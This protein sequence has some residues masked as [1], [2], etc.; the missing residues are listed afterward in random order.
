MRRTGFITALV[1]GLPAALVGGFFVGQ[2]NSPGETAAAQVTVTATVTETT[3][4][5]VTGTAEGT[6]PA[7]SVD[8][9][10]QTPPRPTS[11]ATSAATPEDAYAILVDVNTRWSETKVGPYAWN[12]EDGWV[13]LSVSWQLRRQNESVDGDNC[14]VR[15]SFE[16]PQDLESFST[17]E[18]TNDNR[19]DPDFQRNFTDAG[20][21]TV[22]VVDEVSGATGQR[23]FIVN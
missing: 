11:A 14:A 7:P 23:Q 15:I 5:M 1:T 10:S 22:T 21:Y 2:N 16:G 13:P 17:A 12:R 4:V 18:C 8:G 6:A 19:Y 9:T 3:T 20:E